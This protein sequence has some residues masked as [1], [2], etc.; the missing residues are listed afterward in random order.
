MR[1]TKLPFILMSAIVAGLF[2]LLLWVLFKS[3]APWPF[4]LIPFFFIIFT[5]AVTSR[6]EEINERATINMELLAAVLSA[7]PDFDLRDFLASHGHDDD[8]E[9][10]FEND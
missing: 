9:D 6:L 3:Y 10:D 8:D 7:D 4:F 5:R 1:A 2:S